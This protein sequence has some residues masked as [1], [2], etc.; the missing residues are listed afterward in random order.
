MSDEKFEGVSITLGGRKLIVPA[1]TIKQVRV[2]LADDLKALD[3][4]DA[5][6][7]MMA[8]QRVILAAIRRNYPE[9][10]EEFIEDSLDLNNYKAVLS[11]IMGASGLVQQAGAGE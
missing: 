4:K 3:D 11:A 10:S 1:L 7:S 9:M 8:G 6:V 5:N 2:T